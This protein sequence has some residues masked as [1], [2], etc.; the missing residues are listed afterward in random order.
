MAILIS[1]ALSKA[2][3]VTEKYAIILEQQGILPVTYYS[4]IPSN[5]AFFHAYQLVKTHEA[6]T[7]EDA[8]PALTDFEGYE[9][10]EYICTKSKLLVNIAELKGRPN[11]LSKMLTSF[12][13]SGWVHVWEVNDFFLRL[14]DK[15][16]KE[17]GTAKKTRKG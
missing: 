12:I 15:R 7:L 1:E 13:R 16:I 3:V 8:L 14:R 10:I 17:D 9:C 5:D 4:Y 6:L 2:N 11:A